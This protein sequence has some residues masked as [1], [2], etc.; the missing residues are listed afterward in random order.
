MVP[1]QNQVK[2]GDSFQGKKKT[3]NKNQHSSQ[4]A[5]SQFLQI[6]EPQTRLIKGLNIF[7][8]SGSVILMIVILLGSKLDFLNPKCQN[9]T[10]VCN[11]FA[12][13][14]E[15]NPCEMKSSFHT[16]FFSVLCLETPWINKSL[17]CLAL[18]VS[19]IQRS[20]ITLQRFSE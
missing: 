17:Y 11:S 7:F 13:Q 19:L 15:M 14:S 2:V 10:W 4:L 18:S 16:T 6:C 9:E 1:I 5:F 20:H 12:D 3:S 8:E